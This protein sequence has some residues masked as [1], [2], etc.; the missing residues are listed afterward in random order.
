MPTGTT[1]QPV[2]YFSG[3]GGAKNGPVTA[4]QLQELARQGIV[5]GE[6]LV[7]KEG[8]KEWVPVT[9]IKGLEIK[10]PELTVMPPLPTHA[11]TTAYTR[12]PPRAPSGGGP[13]VGSALLITIGILV[14][15]VLGSMGIAASLNEP[16]LVGIWNIGVLVGT[17]IWAGLDAGRIELSK[18]K[19]G[20]PTGPAI[21][22]I[23]CLLL[24]IVVFPWYLVNKGK[25]ARGTVRLKSA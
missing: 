8:L 7:W 9:R 1:A 24:W 16:A 6:T 25:I 21:T 20:G 12:P 17:S 11:A 13:T 5:N 22:V 15:W 18:Y 10:E 14:V 4:A 23:G 19:V 3:A 2:W